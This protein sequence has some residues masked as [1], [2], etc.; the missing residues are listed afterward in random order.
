MNGGWRRRGGE[1]QLWFPLLTSTHDDDDDDVDD[2]YGDGA[3]DEDF[4][5]L[6]RKLSAVDVQYRIVYKS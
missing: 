3:G 1:D 4:V 2:D 5:Q 6:K